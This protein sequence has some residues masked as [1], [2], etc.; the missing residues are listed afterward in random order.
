MEVVEAV[1]EIWGPDRIGARLSPLGNL[2]D[3]SDRRCG[4]AGIGGDQNAWSQGSLSF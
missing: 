1:S 2:N 3:I 4:C